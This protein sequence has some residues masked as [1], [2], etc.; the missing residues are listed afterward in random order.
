M[1]TCT[2]CEAPLS[3]RQTHFCSAKCKNAH[4]QSYTA[5]HR[6]G[7]ERKWQLVQSFGG[8]C[9]ICGYCRNL[10]ALAFHHK[11]GKEFKLDMRSLSNR[12]L[13]RI[14]AEAA[15]CVLVCANCH[16][17]LHN[18]NLTLMETHS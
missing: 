2:I 4:H 16:A 5:Q 15:K 7:A 17:E 6:R 12:T 8:K 11:E 14:M 3:G 18:P 1:G 10:A 13:K 9:S